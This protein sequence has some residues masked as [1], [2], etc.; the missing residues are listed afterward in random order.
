MSFLKQCQNQWWAS[1]SVRFQ[2]H[3]NANPNPRN[4]VD[5]E[6]VATACGLLVNF[7]SDA[8]YVS[9]F[10]DP[11]IGLVPKLVDAVE[12]AIEADDDICDQVAT[13]ALKTIANLQGHQVEFDDEYK[14]CLYESLHPYFGE[15]ETADD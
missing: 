8:N 4:K 13:N 2:N 7:S 12:Q 5:A 3:T 6:V 10:T 14:R 1:A 11:A 15:G 9:S